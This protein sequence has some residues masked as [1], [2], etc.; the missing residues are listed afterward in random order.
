MRLAGESKIKFKLK[1]Q[2][3]DTLSE[4]PHYTYTDCRCDVY[5]KET[6]Y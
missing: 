1:F 6:R 3:W 4:W 2:Q 5:M